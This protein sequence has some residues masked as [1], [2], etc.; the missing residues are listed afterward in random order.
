MERRIKNISQFIICLAAGLVL[1]FPMMNDVFLLFP[2][3]EFSDQENRRPAQKPVLNLI[4]L[5]PFP[6]AYDKYYNDFFSFRNFLL[7]LYTDLKYRVLHQSPF[8][9]KVITGK[10]GWLFEAGKERNIYEGKFKPGDDSINLIIKEL[11]YRTREYRKKNTRFYFTIAPLKYNIYPEY[12]PF[13]VQ[14]TADS[15]FTEKVIARLKKDSVIRY[16]DLFTPLLSSK[17]S[18][19]LYFCTDNHW[20]PFGGLVASE[21]ILSE[22]RKDFPAVRPHPL[23]DYRISSTRLKWSGNLAQMSGLT[24][25]TFDVEFTLTPIFK[26]RGEPATL[27]GYLCPPGF[28]YPD[29]YE[30][31]MQVQDKSLPGIVIIRDSYFDFQKDYMKEYFSRSTYIFDG[32]Q[33]K[34]NP[35]IVDGEKPDIV[36]LQV[37]E[38]G[39][40]NICDNLSFKKK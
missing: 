18:G 6:A 35:E 26:T 25:K 4:K 33:Y 16:I 34:F 32:W 7:G 8:P 1:A 14:K 36:L 28:P 20:N 17:T 27:G 23:S 29:M 40:A 38:S 10:A 2:P 22:I 5:D 12:L 37:F 39:L 11:E 30:I 3:G 31:A 21:A 13:Y 9:K 15:T 19:Y 24:G